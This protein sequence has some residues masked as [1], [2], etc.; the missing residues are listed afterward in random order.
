M[1]KKTDI[2]TILTKIAKANRG[3]LTPEAVVDFARPASSPIHNRFTW[4][5]N[6]AAHQYRLWE[7]RQMIRVVAVM[8]GEKD[9]KPMRVFVSLMP[10][11]DNESGGYR[12]M[13]AV[14]ADP[15][16][17]DQMLADALAEMEVFE[18]KYQ[19]LV[20]LSEIFTAAKRVRGRRGW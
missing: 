2:K 4:D 7:A 13:T 14:L 17:R 8:V 20:E 16:M 19:A 15:D 5:D 6:E 1:K 11:R 9:Q 12:E 18:A 10:D 3:L